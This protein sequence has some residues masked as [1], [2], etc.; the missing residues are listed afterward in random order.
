MTRLFSIIAV[1]SFFIAAASPGMGQSKDGG[2]PVERISIEIS[3]EAAF[4]VGPMK[5]TL[6]KA[7]EMVLEQNRDTLTGAYD[8]A[9]TDSLYRKFQTKY[10]PFLS[11]EGSGSYKKYPEAM[12]LMAPENEKVISASASLMKNFSSG[13]T[14]AAGMEHIYNKST[15][16]SFSLGCKPVTFGDPQYHRP[17]LFASLKQELLKN[18]FGY[19]DRRQSEILKNAAKM[20]KDA[21]IYQLSGL[22]VGIVVDYWSM[23]ISNSE[24]FNAELQLRE[25]RKVRN[26]ISENVRLGL[27][28]PFDLNYYN[29]LVAGAESGAVMARQK[30]K[31]NMTGASDHP[32]SR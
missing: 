11:I 32:Q 19:S 30:F 21:I 22:V 13:T 7:I 15:L 16:K 17:I 27:A 23:V 18:S 24:L 5:V 2:D 20:Q 14:V 9:M 26:I 28:E 10:S 12:G 3:D 29:T 8:V 25:T 4:Y 31:D 6:G 1:F